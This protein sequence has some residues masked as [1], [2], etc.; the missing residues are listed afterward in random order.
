M[1]IN[2]GANLRY[3][4]DEVP[5]V[6]VKLL[7]SHWCFPQLIKAAGNATLWVGTGE[8]R[9]LETILVFYHLLASVK[10]RVFRPC[11]A[12]SFQRVFLPLKGLL[13]TCVSH[14]HP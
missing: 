2:V 7:Q 14:Q 9:E 8:T 11:S 13:K 12:V 5:R 3:I 1:V 4:I 6:K 10:R